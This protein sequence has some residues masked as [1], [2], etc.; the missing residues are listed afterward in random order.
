MFGRKKTQEELKIIITHG[1]NRLKVRTEGREFQ[2]KEIILSI[3]ALA[4][5]FANIAGLTTE[6]VLL[7]ALDIAEEE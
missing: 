6:E 2:G 3:Y 5:A 7:T 1:K 4:N